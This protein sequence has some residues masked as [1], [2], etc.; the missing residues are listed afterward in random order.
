MA[1]F[2]NCPYQY[3][4]AH[5]LKIPRQGK[6]VFSFG[7]TMHS[8]LQKVFELINEKKGLGQS[9]LFG[10]KANKQQGAVKNVKIN[11]D[12]ILGLYEQSWV[13]DWYESKKQK[14]EHKKKGKDILK[15]FYEKYKDNWPNIVFL[16][17]GFNTKVQVDS[18]IYTIR[19]VIDRID[20]INGKIKIVDYKTG[21]AKDKLSFEEKEQLLLY[22]LAGQELFR[23]EIASLS[24]YYLDNN[25][26]IEFLGSQEDLDKVKEKIVNTIMEIKKCEFLP[27]PSALCKYCDFFDIC[28]FRKT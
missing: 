10:Y 6:A 21:K 22:Q 13:D 8:T 27:K 5:I 24:F 17:K 16:E 15:D 20:E 19:G 14:E 12:E 26:E 1:A 7:K 28:E 23:K 4:F 18:Q 11:I 2:S 3:R 25:S 9:D